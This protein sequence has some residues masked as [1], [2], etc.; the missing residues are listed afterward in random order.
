MA[1]LQALKDSDSEGAGRVNKMRIDDDLQ[2][3]ETVEPVESVELDEVSDLIDSLSP[4]QIALL[5][6]K[7]NKED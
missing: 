3:V 6:N 2:P 1:Q 4:E 5:K 7:L